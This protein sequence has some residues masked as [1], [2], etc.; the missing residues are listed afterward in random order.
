MMNG[1]PDQVRNALATILQQDMCT[2]C[3]DTN[4]LHKISPELY[5]EY[6]A[7][8][9]KLSE[10]T[11]LP[12]FEIE[13]TSLQQI[14]LRYRLL[15]ANTLNEFIQTN[16][17]LN[18]LSSEQM[19]FVQNL[20]ILGG[21]LQSYTQLLATAENHE[22]IYDR[23]REAAIL[24]EIDGQNA[25]EFLRNSK[26]M[27]ATL[28]RDDIKEVVITTKSFDSLHGIDNTIDSVKL[29]INNMTLGLT[30]S[31]TFFIFY[32]IPG[33]GKTALSESIAT[34][35][36][37]GEYYKFDQSFFASTY[38][39][40]TESRIRNIFETVRAN[41]NKKFTIIIDEA[42]N[43]LAPTPIQSHLNSI[44]ILLQ[45]EIGSYESFETNLIIIAI[46]NYLTRIDQTFR[47]RAT[48]ELLI[49]R[50]EVKDCLDFLES[51]LTPSDIPF[52][53]Q[54]KAKLLLTFD[55][56]FAYTNSDMGRLAKNI[57]DTFLTHI[58]AQ[59][60]VRICISMSNELIYFYSNEDLDAKPVNLRDDEQFDLDV[61]DT[62]KKAMTKLSEFLFTNRL[63]LKKYR[64]YYAP[65]MDVLSQA[66]KT[67]ST[68]TKETAAGYEVRE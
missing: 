61:V 58:D 45:T 14:G 8:N 57:K 2:T 37:N 6:N 12:S 46:T 67:A 20:T 13:R 30:D 7:L 39:G 23:I 60:K 1:T 40:V 36:S 48:Q 29:L 59:Q 54:Y 19:V 38:L 10:F 32:G 66:M 50:P 26:K 3:L 55:N 35:F 44:K 22:K 62:Y 28:G 33:T 41:K 16:D 9:N 31:Y 27:S 18:K 25:L 42:D 63:N 11:N 64:R 51:Q 21:K 24:N 15:M 34:Y 43:V 68:L 47:R 17:D 53:P 56:K 52:N 4:L 49:R 5:G 65:K